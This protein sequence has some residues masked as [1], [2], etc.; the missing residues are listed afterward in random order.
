MTLQRSRGNDPGPHR[1]DAESP[2]EPVKQYH[3]SGS[4]WCWCCPNVDAFQ[5][6]QVL[7]PPYRTT[8]LIMTYVTFASNF[9]YYG[10]IYGLPR[11]LQAEA[12]AQLHEHPHTRLSWSPAAGVFFSAV[13]E[14]P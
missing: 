5:V 11:T 3:A 9:A 8:T 10:M 13:F 4:R 7:Q 12:A 1:G 2:G 14:I 6:L